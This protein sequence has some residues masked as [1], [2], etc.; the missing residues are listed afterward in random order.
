MV[1]YK[2]GRY[3]N[4]R[5]VTRMEKVSFLLDKEVLEDIKQLAT[6]QQRSISFIVRN[7]VEKGLN[8]G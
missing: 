7:L 6:D 1:Q 8:K 5:E 2:C 3:R 4:R